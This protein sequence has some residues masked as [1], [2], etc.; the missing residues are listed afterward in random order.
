MTQILSDAFYI[1]VHYTWDNTL[2]GIIDVDVLGILQTVRFPLAVFLRDRVPG[3]AALSGAM[4]R[5]YQTITTQPMDTEWRLVGDET[6]ADGLSTRIQ[7]REGTVEFS[8]QTYELKYQDASISKMDTDLQRDPLVEVLPQRCI[9][10]AVHRRRRRGVPP[11]PGP[12][13]PPPPPPSPSDV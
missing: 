11:P 13:S 5:I 3:A 1:M 8:L 12:P 4:R 7:N 6:A 2:E 10:T 9:G